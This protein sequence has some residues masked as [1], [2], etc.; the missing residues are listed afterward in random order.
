LDPGV[1]LEVLKGLEQFMNNRKYNS[2]DAIISAAR[3]K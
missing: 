2:L 1:A 3:K